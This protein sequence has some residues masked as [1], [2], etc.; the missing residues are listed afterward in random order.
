FYTAKGLP[1]HYLIH[2]REL[3][4]NRK[5][6]SIT[7]STVANALARI[8][9]REA[10]GEAITGPKKIG[11]YGASYLYPVLLALDVLERPALPGQ[12]EFTDAAIVNEI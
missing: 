3:F 12:E 6:K 4:V 5:N 2:G 9:A 10:A 11:C 7:I 1:F 8:K